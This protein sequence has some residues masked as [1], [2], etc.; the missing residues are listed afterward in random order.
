LHATALAVSYV[1]ELAA[2]VIGLT[3]IAATFSAQAIVCAREFGM[4]RPRGRHARA[5]P[6][7]LAF[8]GRLVT[9]MA[10]AVGLAPGL[11]IAWISA[12]AMRFIERS[13]VAVASRRATASLRARTAP[14]RS[15]VS[16]G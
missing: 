7:A 15:E 6:A 2:I 14:A 1:L 4:L 16:S 8:E 13:V 11:A 12:S 9:L 10:T 3:G 5:D